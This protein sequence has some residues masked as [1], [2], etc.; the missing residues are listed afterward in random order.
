MHREFGVINSYTLEISFC[1]ATQGVYK[2]THFS[3]L[4]LKVSSHF[5]SHWFCLLR[6]KDMGKNFCKTL[7]RFSEP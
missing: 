5:F 2:D 1:G 6:V 7:V 4:L 3:Q